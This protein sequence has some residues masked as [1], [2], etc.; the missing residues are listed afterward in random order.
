[1]RMKKLTELSLH[2]YTAKLPGI[3]LIKKKNLLDNQYETAFLRISYKSEQLLY[4][5]NQ[6][7]KNVCIS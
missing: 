7:I 1:M 3:A 2:C 4:K 5:F 6:N